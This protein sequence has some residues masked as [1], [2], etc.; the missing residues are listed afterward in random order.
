MS[1]ESLN[2]RFDELLRNT[3]I[4]NYAALA[5]QVKYNKDSWGLIQQNLEQE[6]NSL[7]RKQKLQTAGIFA[8]T[9]ILGSM[10]FIL[11]CDMK[12]QLSDSQTME[13]STNNHTDGTKPDIL[14]FFLPACKDEESRDKP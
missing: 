5:A 11:S 7:L 10:I 14:S 6:R 12:A 9:L 1:N 4:Q 8:S 13:R 3:T 2:D